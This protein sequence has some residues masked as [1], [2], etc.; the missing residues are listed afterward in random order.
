M[1]NMLGSCLGGREEENEEQTAVI[2]CRTSNEC[3]SRLES[4]KQSRKLMVIDFSA[5]WCGPCKFMEPIVDELSIRYKD[6]QFIKVDVD[7]N[8]GF[9][10]RF[11]IDCMPTFVFLREGKEVDRLSGAGKVELEN[12]IKSNRPASLRA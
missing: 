2:V 5:A 7:E 12:K 1:G 6:V 3:E 11:G 9:A 8:T 10:R 4:S